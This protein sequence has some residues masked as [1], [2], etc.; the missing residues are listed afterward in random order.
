[1]S[2]LREKSPYSEDGDDKEGRVALIV[3]NLT[4]Y[5]TD[6]TE[7]PGSSD[8]VPYPGEFA[9]DDDGHIHILL[10]D[11]ESN[12]VV[13]LSGSKKLREEF[14]DLKNKGIFS[15][16]EAFIFN[17]QINILYFDND[18]MT[19]KSRDT[20]TFNASYKYYA[21]RGLKTDD[22]D[23]IYYTGIQSSDGTGEVLSHLVDMIPG[24][25]VDDNPVSIMGTGKLL[26]PMVHTNNYVVEFYD[27]DTLLVDSIPFQG[28]SV[29]HMTFDMTPDMAVTDL[30]IGTNTPAGNGDPWSCKLHVGQSWKDLGLRVFLLYAGDSERRDVTHEW[31]SGPGDRLH[32][33]GI[34][35]ID[36]TTPTEEDGEPQKFTITYYLSQANVDNPLVDPDNLSLTREVKVYIEPDVND[37]PLNVVLGLWK[38]T[39]NLETKVNMKIF[40]LN[41]VGENKDKGVLRDITWRMKMSTI[42]NFTFVEG[43]TEDESRFVGNGS[44]TGLQSLTLTV[45]YATNQRKEF[46]GKIFV[47]TTSTESRL[48]YSFAADVGNLDNEKFNWRNIKYIVGGGGKMY[49]KLDGTDSRLTPAKLKE[50]Y[51][52]S[53]GEDV[54]V[55]PNKFAIKSARNPLFYHTEKID[56]NNAN[57]EFAFVTGS[58][59]TETII[60]KTP[61]IVEFYK[62]DTNEH[63][64]VISSFV[65]GAELFYIDTSA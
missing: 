35:D 26:V 33:D 45:P 59:N 23:P 57:T 20:R 43:D 2:T 16:A 29:R 10:R 12:K 37:E 53:S 47:P 13:D 60:D 51:T 48:K 42:A 8:D 17:R 36:T 55:V 11:P 5:N 15:N 18:R 19:V 54:S 22:G 58:R 24:T 38:S 49:L 28:V 30:A 1:M 62:E 56:I 31:G 27:S 14:D 6:T 46:S 61:V 25:D 63:G 21:V 50:T 41:A 32:I 65:T 44:V 64:E 52:F 40:T 39:E 9:Y 4:E 3:S 34:E 7:N